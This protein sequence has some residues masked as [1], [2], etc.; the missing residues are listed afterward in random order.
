MMRNKCIVLLK[1]VVNR[2]LS[3]NLLHTVFFILNKSNFNT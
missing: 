2:R 1:Y 3:S